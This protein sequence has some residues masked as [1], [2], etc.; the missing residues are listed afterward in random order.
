MLIIGGRGAEP[1]NQGDAGIKAGV[2]NAFPKVDAMAVS[3]STARACQSAVPV[4]PGCFR[5]TK[6]SF[7]SS[8]G[9]PTDRLGQRWRPNLFWA[10]H[11]FSSTG[12][13]CSLSLIVQ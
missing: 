6:I 13:L 8:T 10:A 12:K 2:E 5:V 11:H 1:C 7:N 3:C 9:W 4:Q